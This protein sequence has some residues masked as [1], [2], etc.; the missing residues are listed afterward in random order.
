VPD[1]R[2]KQKPATFSGG[3]GQKDQRALDGPRAKDVQPHTQPRMGALKKK[4]NVAKGG[5]GG[6]KR[7]S[8]ENQERGGNFKKTLKKEKVGGVTLI[9]GNAQVKLG[10][11]K[12]RL[13][14]KGEGETKRPGQSQT[15][16][17]KRLSKGIGAPPGGAQSQ[18]QKPEMLSGPNEG[19]EGKRC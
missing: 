16:G 18:G 12:R 3:K 15:G 6:R 5:K 11:R 7:R 10:G 19:G 2:T 8:L 4:K 17:R 13:R 9:K 14:I 1:Q